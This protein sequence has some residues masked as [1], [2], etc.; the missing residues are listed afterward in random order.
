MDPAAKRQAVPDAI[1]AASWCALAAIADL[2]AMLFWVVMQS[3]SVE[4]AN[5]RAA[6]PDWACTARL[7]RT[8]NIDMCTQ[9][10]PQMGIRVKSAIYHVLLVEEIIVAPPTMQQ[11]MGSAIMLIVLLAAGRDTVFAL[12]EMKVIRVW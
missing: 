12:T 10:T 6:R 9:N 3:D 11:H 5:R 1:L 8:R 2:V 4:L 7:D